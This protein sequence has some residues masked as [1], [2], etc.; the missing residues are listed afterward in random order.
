MLKKTPLMEQ[1]EREN[2]KKYAIWNGL[3]TEQFKIWKAKKLDPN[4]NPRYIYEGKDGF[5]I[6][7][8]SWIFYYSETLNTAI[9]RYGLSD[10]PD[11][12]KLEQIGEAIFDFMNRPNFRIGYPVY[13]E[14]AFHTDITRI[15][16]YL[17]SI[18]KQNHSS[19]KD[20][21]DFC[22]KVLEKLK[23]ANDD[24]YFRVMTR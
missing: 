21:I 1:Y 15:A 19:D 17:S 14:E 2:P 3:V 13:C 9:N 5:K 8:K 23:K 20:Y 18:N 12:N 4:Y 10:N 16:G 22:K 7:R 6:A 11:W 24:D